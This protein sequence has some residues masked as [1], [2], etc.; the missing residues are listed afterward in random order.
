MTARKL[1]TV[2]AHGGAI[3]LLDGEDNGTRFKITLP[4]L[5]DEEK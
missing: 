2:M 1:V 5:G 4:L 3:L